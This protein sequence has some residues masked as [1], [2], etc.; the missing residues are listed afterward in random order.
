MAE[1]TMIVNAYPVVAG[2]SGSNA[3]DGIPISN[4]QPPVPHI[5]NIG[6]YRNFNTVSIGSDIFDTTPRNDSKI[7][8]VTGE[9][10]YDDI[11]SIERGDKRVLIVERKMSIAL[12][13]LSKL[14]SVWKSGSMYLII[15]NGDRLKFSDVN[16]MI[17]FIN[18]SN[19]IANE[20]FIRSKE[21]FSVTGYVP[22]DAS[23][24]ADANSGVTIGVGV[25]LGGKTK[26]SMLSDGITQ[27]FVTILEP[28]LGLKGQTAQNK[29]TNSPLTLTENQAMEL[30]RNYINRFST[31]VA[32]KYNA[33]TGSNFSKLPLGTRTAVVSVS[34]QYGTNLASATPT[35]W[36]QV[37]QGLWADAVKNLNDFKDSY[38]TRRKSEA[39]LIQADINSGKLK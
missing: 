28:Y 24:H 13:E 12:G 20:S 29:L 3:P 9:I 21:G 4:W 1:D 2:W 6:T 22:K 37:T 39:S 25:D 10:P 26:A 5:S 34:Y 27:A 33:A 17:S 8:P 30:S 35:F 19:R 31:V 23:S 14:G 38:A 16:Q 32:Q 11:V 18:N 15:G 7:D 36:K